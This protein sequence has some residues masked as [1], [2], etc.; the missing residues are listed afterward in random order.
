LNQK[1]LVHSS[2]NV[3][4]IVPLVSGETG[5]G[6]SFA[7]AQF[8]DGIVEL[9]KIKH[10]EKRIHG[11]V[12][13][14]QSVVEAFSNISTS[15]SSN[16]NCAS[17]VT[18]L[19]F[20]KRGSLVGALR[21]PYLFNKQHVTTSFH[22]GDTT[23]HIFYMLLGGMSVSMKKEYEIVDNPSQYP[24][25]HSRSTSSPSAYA[26]KY[27]DLVA[28]FKEL[29]INK[30][31]EGQIFSILAAILHLSTL[32]FQTHQSKHND[33]P[34]DI[35]NRPSLEK[36]AKLLGVS[37]KALESVLVFKSRRVN[38]DTF[39]VFLEP[40]EAIEQ[41]DALA[42][43]LYNALF[44]SIVEFLNHR[45][46]KSDF[47]SVISVIDFPGR[48]DV[49]GNFENFIANFNQ[50]LLYDLVCSR[51]KA[52]FDVWLSE[53]G[54]KNTSLDQP[55]Q[56]VQNTIELYTR[57]VQ[58]LFYLMDEASVE[59]LGSPSSGFA[60]QL[61]DSYNR[62]NG[63][64]GSVHPSYVP[65]KNRSGSFSVVHYGNFQ[66]SYS[67]MDFITCNLD[68]IS[69]DFV[70]LFVGGQDSAGSGNSFVKE[71]MERNHSI[72]Y[73]GEA[74]ANIVGAQPILTPERPFQR[75]INQ[76]SKFPSRNIGVKNSLST[77]SSALLNSVAELLSKL[78][79][80]HVWTLFCL[81]PNGST[82]PM[83]FDS[84]IVKSQVKALSLTSF[85]PEWS[86]SFHIPDFMSTYQGPIKELGINLTAD[87]ASNVRMVGDALGWNFGQNEDYYLSY[88]TVYL[89]INPFITLEKMLY[90]EKKKQKKLQRK[91][92]TEGTHGEDVVSVTETQVSDETYDDNE[93]MY[94]SKQYKPATFYDS[95][96][97]LTEKG[98]AQ[99]GAK[100]NLDK[101]A[102][103]EEVQELSRQR[104]NWLRYVKCTTFWI[105]EKCIT[106]RMER[107]DVRLAWRE[108]VALVITILMLSA[109][110]LFYILGLG[111]LLCPK[112]D[113]Y[114]M[115]EI[116]WRQTFEDS[117]MVTAYG[118]VFEITDFALVHQKPS[119]LN[120]N[121]LFEFVGGLDVRSL[122]AFPLTDC[123]TSAEEQA[124]LGT[125][126][127]IPFNQSLLLSYHR[128]TNPNED[129]Q[130]MRKEYF[131]G[132]LVWDLS[133]LKEAASNEYAYYMM[134]KNEIFD[135]SDYINTDVSD[136]VSNILFPGELGTSFR[137]KPSQLDWTQFIETKMNDK[138]REK[139]L[140][141][142]RHL[143][144][145]GMIDTRHGARC[146][147]SEYMLLTASIL[148]ASVIVVK[149][150]AALQLGS[151]RIPENYDRFV[152]VQVPCYTEGEESLRRTIDTCATMDYDDKRKLLFIIADGMIIG[153]GNDKPTPRIVL[154]ILG[155]DPNLNP[156]PV[157]Y[158]AL[159]EGNRQYN[160][161][162]V[163]SGLYEV[164]GHLVPYLVVVKCG[165]ESERSRPGNRG[166]RD[167]QLILMKFLSKV[168][169]DAPMNPMEIE[170][171]HQ[172]KNVI[173][174][175]P[176]FYEYLLMVDA[177]T[178]VLPDSLTRLIAA[179]LHDKRIMGIC[180]ETMLTNDNQSWVTM[181]QVY[182]YYIS[183]HLSKAFESLFGTVTC[184]PGCF[185]MYRIRTPDNNV[186]LIVSN[187][188]V[189]DYA[190]NNVDT[191]HKKNLLSLG[192]DRY[193]TTLM[194]KHFPQRKLVFTSDAKCKTVAPDQWSVLLSQRRRWIN[195]TVHNLFELLFLDQL[196]GFCLFSMRF[197]VFIDLFATLVQ[198]A[199]VCYLIY[200]LILIGTT[201]QD[202]KKG[203]SPIP[204][205]S[206][207]MLAAVYGLQAFIFIIKRRW[208]H[209]G[210]MV[211]YVLGI[212]LFSFFIPL[213]SF[214]HFDDFS[215]GNTRVVV[216]DG[217]KQKVMYAEG[218]GDFK[219]EDIP[220]VK[221]GEY[222]KQ[223]PLEKDVNG[224]YGGF[225]DQGSEY[226]G[227]GY[228]GRMDDLRSV[229]G[230]PTFPI[231]PGMPPMPY[232]QAPPPMPA[233][234][235]DKRLSGLSYY[236]VTSQ[237]NDSNVYDPNAQYYTQAM[238]TSYPSDDLLVQEINRIL[239]VADLASI[240]KKQIREALQ[241]QFRVDLSHKRDFIHR[242]I[243]AYLEE[244]R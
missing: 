155:V 120:R 29:G 62:H 144:K 197:V 79:T 27:S 241:L 198:P 236:G 218:D 168:H 95:S 99:V 58:G 107:P 51:Q 84:K 208:E 200:L 136:E 18:Q 87:A 210:W 175:D 49:S 192:E 85:R 212:P 63:S 110:M 206:L 105:P 40:D 196:C 125:V 89:G 37:S 193:L 15:V 140:K 14:A 216:G 82:T 128:H 138:D 104:R 214:W 188:I 141:C 25:L 88:S 124:T 123:G 160:M 24:Y 117:P 94:G 47:D 35:K 36:V 233:A 176:S 43:M 129:L 223:D 4:V 66:A 61:L 139:A 161:A 81:L 148:M 119:G 164:E 34:C 77:T 187:S 149:F 28:S 162:K 92:G 26:P 10:K 231:A 50:D 16:S 186:P 219:A 23:F 201:S 12:A 111:K 97:T 22:P 83:S 45:T 227:G 20:N 203:G 71:M 30:K 209:I 166:K 134:Y 234:R 114:G 52:R 98:G 17:I 42:C 53:I 67:T 170:V 8:L 152:I 195:S 48:R 205:I 182:E 65:A 178:E 190:E 173:G 41:R 180:G 225:S 177:D 185:C 194:L 238:D 240:T 93:S 109:V 80:C 156:E 2:S 237:P 211:I 222:Q 101:N 74:S 55:I 32:E 3:Y 220:V 46:A 146:Q 102:S 75:G 90:D 184:L 181:I 70:T 6:K 179:C 174:V 73:Q 131:A 143:F 122:F 78:E 172:L 191:L 39:T 115:N 183:H 207:L 244:R 230:G 121:Q 158:H 9:S 133:Y 56:Q 154:D 189:N 142:A 215:W 19:L 204:T 113:V 64:A 1:D 171:Y 224:L 69:P 76:A 7:V 221:W 126:T 118:M 243:D 229:A 159:G 13:A 60:D 217:G 132:D 54:G 135:M 147:F 31:I 38:G 199:T 106:R 228:G 235:P 153:S 163:Y 239:S 86:S 68:S 151:R 103:K 44:R 5:S 226:N 167:S 165:K 112:Q 116:A 96:Q 21:L 202:P 100:A 11:Q 33:E 242:V 157:A 127:L 57:P 150:L 59:Y 137:K 72:S 108:K 169:Y 91:L 232:S 145:V 213:Y 130:K